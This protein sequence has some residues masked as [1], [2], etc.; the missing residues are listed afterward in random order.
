MKILLRNETFFNN[1]IR[2]YIRLI[3]IIF[4]IIYLCTNLINKIKEAIQ[5]F[6]DF[7]STDFEKIEYLAQSKKSYDIDNCFCNELKTVQK[8]IDEGV[9]YYNFLKKYNYDD[10]DVDYLFNT[11]V[12]AREGNLMSI[13]SILGA[14]TKAKKDELRS[15]NFIF[16]FY[17][18]LLEKYKMKNFIE[19]YIG[20]IED[21]DYKATDII[22]LF[23]LG[24][25]L[26]KRTI[27][28][29]FE[30]CSTLKIDIFGFMNFFEYLGHNKK[31]LEEK[32]LRTTN[33]IDYR[34]I[35]FYIFDNSSRVFNDNSNGE[36]LNFVRRILLVTNNENIPIKFRILKSRTEHSI[37]ACQWCS[38]FNE[39]LQKTEK[40]LGCIE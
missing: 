5:N 13:N 23:S 27:T 2:F 18:K 1:S 38:L 14:I 17:K 9:L 10:D 29:D 20:E 28:R 15:L 25:L 30:Y 24:K 33:K 40:N 34:N 19:K 26:G 4:T 22:L 11:I 3:G 36:Q 7:E 32:F 31:L 21:L 35:K 39:N 8:K 6:W 16:S 37:R 12:R